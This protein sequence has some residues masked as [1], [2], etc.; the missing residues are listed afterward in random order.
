MRRCNPP[1]A[2]ALSDASSHL[3]LSHLALSH[4][5]LSHLALA[6]LALPDVQGCPVN[7]CTSFSDLADARAACEADGTCGGVTSAPGGAG[8]W[9]LR[10]G[11][12]PSASPSNETSYAAGTRPTSAPGL[13]PHLRRDLAHI[14]AGT[15]PT[16]APGLG[17]H[18]RRESA[19]I[20]AGTRPASAPGLGP[21]LRRGSARICAGTRPT[22]AAGLGP[23][24]RRGSARICAGT[25]PTSA[26][27]LGPHLRRGSA[28][29][30][31]GTRPTSAAGV[32][33]HLRRDSQV[34]VG[35]A[36][37]VP[38][39]R[40]RRVVVRRSTGR[41]ARRHR[42]GAGVPAGLSPTTPSQ[43]VPEPTGRR[44]QVRARR[45]RVHG[46]QPHGR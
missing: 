39:S 33:P 46:A 17:P 40:R 41:D 36:V 4:L 3:A 11:F 20:C 14:C 9:Q 27:G 23:H 1:R 38:S 19:H 5:A 30:C 35:A 21:H 2:R 43:S 44:G 42:M 24:L 16:S 18:L 37:R 32:G 29:I 7:P 6:H 26:A 15:R 28:H 8:P 13:G 10:A 45:R 34:R 31:G 25:R 12:S 22:S